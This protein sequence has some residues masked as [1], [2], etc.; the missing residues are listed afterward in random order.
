ME[1]THS[2]LAIVKRD[3]SDSRKC[4]YIEVNLDSSQDVSDSD[5]PPWF[6]N[7][8]K[9][10]KLKTSIIMILIYSYSEGKMEL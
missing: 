3:N 4:Y 7:R 1:V 2:S 8:E 10:K 9:A 6:W 5:T